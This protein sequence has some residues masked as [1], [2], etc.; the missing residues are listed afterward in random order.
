MRCR[1][2]I[3]GAL[4][5]TITMAGCKMTGSQQSQVSSIGIPESASDQDCLA[6]RSVLL[7]SLNNLIDQGMRRDA[8]EQIRNNPD[9]PN[10]R[11]FTKPIPPIDVT[12]VLSVKN[13][14]KLMD[15]IIEKEGGKCHKE[16]LMDSQC[17]FYHRRGGVMEASFYGKISYARLNRVLGLSLHRRRLS[18]F[19]DFLK[20]YNSVAGDEARN[21]TKGFT[22]TFYCGKHAA[23]C[24]SDIAYDIFGSLGICLL[25]KHQALLKDTGIFD[26][27]GYGYHPD[28]PGVSVVEDSLKNFIDRSNRLSQ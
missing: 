18:E 20:R 3:L 17:M 23:K 22:H 25:E 15:L 8:G 19:D 21:A 5:A 2:A 11:Q 14:R 6:W 16:L 1:S 4:A 12:E 24:T 7:F 10:Y 13:T 9:H 26:L 27:S 28:S